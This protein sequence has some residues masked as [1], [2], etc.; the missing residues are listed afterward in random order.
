MQSQW[1][2]WQAEQLPKPNIK[3]LEKLAA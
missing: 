1:D 3:P 2:L